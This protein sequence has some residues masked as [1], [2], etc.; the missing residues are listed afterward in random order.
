MLRSPLSSPARISG[1]AATSPCKR[2]SASYCSSRIGM[3]LSPCL[4]KKRSSDTRARREVVAQMLDY[5]ANSAASW[6]VELLRTWFE[7]T[8]EQDSV[9]PQE[10]LA[11]TLGV[12]E[13]DR[14]WETVQTNLAAERI[15]LVFVAD[16]I[17]PELRSIVE[18]LN[19]QMQ[20]TEVY[21]IE[22]KQ[23]V[24][25]V[26]ERQTIVPRVI[27]RTEKPT[28]L[29]RQWDE[30]SL[31]EDVRE[32][33]DEAASGV[34]ERLLAWA[35]DRRLVIRYGTGAKYATVQL[36]FERDGT[37]VPTV[38]LQ[39]DG[40]VYLY[41]STLP[42]LP[43]FDDRE[44]R[45]ELRIRLAEAVPA[46]AIRPEDVQT[47]PTIPLATLT[48]REAL[49]KFFAAFDWAFEEARRT[50]TQSAAG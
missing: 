34:V 21:A 1:C 16:S 37:T 14:F 23:Y 15:R 27:G 32:R 25:A 17:P 50:Q 8:C 28:R 11:R 41:F 48:D 3:K 40:T 44:R 46:A 33:L 49:G 22:V 30:A 20:E 2:T 18:F 43:P 19:R 24:D 12:T 36:R 47:D 39:S 5:A 4:K 29:R 38:F 45:D 6:N 13:P 9:G 26:G 10:R 7:E 42:S 35:A 31:L